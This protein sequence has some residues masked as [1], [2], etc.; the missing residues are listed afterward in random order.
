MTSRKP[1]LIIATLA[2]ALAAGPLAAQDSVNP[3]NNSDTQR[4]TRPGVLP[5]TVIDGSDGADGILPGPAPAPV[6]PARAECERVLAQAEQDAA[7]LAAGVPDS[8]ASGAADPEH[9]I[10][11]EQMAILEECRELLREQSEAA[12]TRDG[13][14]N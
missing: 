1:L 6:T 9:A 2:S 13:E 7:G 12:D 11:T 5:G 4:D 14:G 8:N 3:G 10:E